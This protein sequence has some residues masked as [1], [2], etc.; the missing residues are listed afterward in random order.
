MK[1]IYTLVLL[2]VSSV[3]FGQTTGPTQ[4]EVQGFMPINS[5]DRVDLYSG[6]LN[7]NI[8]LMT[9]P[10]PEGMSYP[11]NIFYNSNLSMEMMPSMVGL[12]W[13]LNTGAI[14][15]NLRG[16]PDDFKGDLVKQTTYTKPSWTISL[17]LTDYL[18]KKE[19]AGLDFQKGISAKPSLSMYYNNYSGIGADF[20]LNIQA[21]FTDNEKNQGNQKSGLIGNLGLNFD[22]QEGFNLSP[23]FLIQSKD[24]KI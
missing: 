20:G 10:G 24:L 18:F 14:V 13:N 4:P 23:S 17:D 5:N 16:L 21:V 12:G 9:I 7:K 1:L 8:P 2:L 22:N 11:I 15:R 19:A 6:D 3:L